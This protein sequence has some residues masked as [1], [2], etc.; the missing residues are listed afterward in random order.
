MY[1]IN[2]NTCIILSYIPTSRAAYTTNNSNAAKELAQAMAFGKMLYRD[3]TFFNGNN[4]TRVYNNSNNGTVT[5]TQTTGNNAPNDS[6]QVLVIKNTGT[7]SPN[8]G[9]FHWGTGTAYRKIFITRIIAKIPSGRDISYH[10]NNS[11]KTASK[12]S[13]IELRKLEIF[14]RVMSE[15]IKHIEVLY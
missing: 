8:C 10:S 14:L 2:N 11:Q 15:K 9:G 4:S 7:A 13:F 6:K 3:P 1:I 5:I 12:K